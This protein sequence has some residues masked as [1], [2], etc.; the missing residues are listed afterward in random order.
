MYLSLNRYLKDRFGKRV[1]K[2]PLDAEFTCPNRD[3]TKA[4]GGCIYCNE[5]GAGTG[6]LARGT[7]LRTQLIQGMKWATRRYGAQR[8]LAYLQSF[9]NTYGPIERLRDIYST[10]LGPK[11]VVGISIATRPDCIDEERL[12]LIKEVA[13]QKLVWMEYGLQSA[14]D[15]T[16]KRINRGHSFQDFVNAVKITHEFEIPVCC[17]VIFG[18]PGETAKDMQNTIE[19]LRILKVEGI[20]FH[21]L[22]VLKGTF[23]QQMW[24]RGDYEP[25]SQGLYTDLVAWA[26]KRLGD[27]CVVHRLTA[28]HSAD[29]LLAPLWSLKKAE[30]IQ[31]IHKKLITHGHSE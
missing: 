21:Q 18:L 7:D 29:S 2:I 17:H 20:K 5:K 1:Q 28:D 14:N 25:I 10:V 24:E 22:S 15:A 11:E 9:S 16:L 23:L 4:T 12:R 30:T 8:F 27:T 19:Q 31:I 3:G 26:I 13:G 6:A